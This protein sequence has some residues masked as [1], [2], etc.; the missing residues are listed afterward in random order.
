MQFSCLSVEK[1]WLIN[2][3]KLVAIFTLWISTFFKLSKFLMLLWVAVCV[4]CKGENCFNFKN[5]SFSFPTELMNF[6][7]GSPP[8]SF[9][10]SIENKSFLRNKLF[11]IFFSL[12]FLSCIQKALQHRHHWSW[13]KLISTFFWYATKKLNEFTPT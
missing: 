13:H 11:L 7:F 4:Y 10:L 3:L 5:T 2:K 1:S 8:F 12:F 9:S 6:S